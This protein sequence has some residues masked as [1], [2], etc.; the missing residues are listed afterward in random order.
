MNADNPMYTIEYVNA[1]LA[2]VAG[3]VMQATG[4]TEFEDCLWVGD[5]QKAKNGLQR[6]SI[7]TYVSINR[8]T[9]L[10]SRAIHLRVIS[11]L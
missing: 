2:S 8:D 3:T 11:S 10:L 5:W 1:C 7:I 6:V 9:I 4:R